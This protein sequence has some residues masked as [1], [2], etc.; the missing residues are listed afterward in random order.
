MMAISVR[1]LRRQA[2]IR[3][4]D[5]RALA[6]NAGVSEASVSRAV[7]GHCVRGITALKLVQALR[8]HPPVPE[9]EL[10]ILSGEDRH[11]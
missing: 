11:L 3:G 5:Q 9:L 8:R 10:L 7:A 4:W 1:E 2:G 6:R